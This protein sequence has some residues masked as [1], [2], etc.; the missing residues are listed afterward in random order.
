M[1]A[2][3]IIIL[4]AV[5]FALVMLSIWVDEIFQ[6]P[7]WLFSLPAEP[8]NYHE[9]IFESGVILVLGIVVM[10]ITI[11]FVRRITQLEQLLPICMFCK[12][13]RKENGDPEKQ[14]SWEPMEQYLNERTG[15]RFSHGFCPDCGMKHYGKVIGDEKKQ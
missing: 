7:A 13:I 2:L 6:L 8:T 3:P 4:E 15:A 11:H 9:A 12:K 1:K 10:D 5:A 14:E